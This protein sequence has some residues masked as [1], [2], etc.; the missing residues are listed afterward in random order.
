MDIES[1]FERR[2]ISA[3]DLPDT[4]DVVATIESVGV[5]ELDQRDGTTQRKPIVTLA[6]P[7]VPGGPDP[8]GSEQDEHEDHQ[9]ARR[10]G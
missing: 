2:F 4:G 9:V 6:Q 5:E 1:T 10:I 3:V 8:L 7:L